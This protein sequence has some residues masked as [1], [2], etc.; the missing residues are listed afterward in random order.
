MIGAPASCPRRCPSRIWRAILLRP[1]LLAGAIGF[2]APAA[3]AAPAGM[4][5]PPVCAYRILLSGPEA[6]DLTVHAECRSDGAIELRPRGPV[7]R[8]N[9]VAL[10]VN[11]RPVDRLDLFDW[12][13]PAEGGQARFGYRFD[14]DKAAAD[15]GSMDGAR[16]FG[17]T[18]VAPLR[19]WLLAPADP[20]A[21]LQLTVD[22]PRG[23]RILTGLAPA[24]GGTAGGP[25]APLALQAGDLDYAGYALLGTFRSYEFTLP[26][27]LEA[28]GSGPARITLALPD[29]PFALPDE[30]L[31]RWLIRSA[32]LV[33]GYWGGMPTRR[34]LFVLAPEPMSGGVMFGRVRGGGGT[35]GFISLGEYTEREQLYR[36]W[37][38]VHEMMH[39]G[40]P[41]MRD[42]FWFM[43]GF[44]TYAEPVARARAGWRSEAEVWEEFL[45]GMP[46][47]LP[48]MT[49][50][51]MDGRGVDTVYWGG[52]LFMLLADVAIRVQS[53]NTLGLEDCFRAILARRGDASRRWSLAEALAACDAATGGSA[54]SRL[55]QRHVD[56]AH[57]LDLDALWQDLGVRQGPEGITLDDGAPLA[58]VR[59]A[60]AG[61]RALPA[62]LPVPSGAAPPGHLPAAGGHDDT[63]QREGGRMLG[64]GS[65]AGSAE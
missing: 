49:G 56:S 29:P 65:G 5:G 58:A 20:D 57:P 10:T 9:L 51:G 7:L 61:R 60:I 32:H 55:V 41:F 54:V 30:E 26:A 52:A 3:G 48:A 12:R 35:T 39:L 34:S 28:P 11:G 46:R 27:A 6:H 19:S 4:P 13:V 2:W 1:L 17:R 63:G 53:G 59:R 62:G 16:R 45:R 23:G 40:S 18:V 44:A 8:R 38:L 21:Q 22:A 47:G 15:E 33:A 31:L 14:L 36:S 50:G 25:R 42:G 64:A 43:E 24:G 37:E